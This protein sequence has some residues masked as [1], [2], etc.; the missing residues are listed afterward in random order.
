M[1]VSYI[2][3]VIRQKSKFCLQGIMHMNILKTSVQAEIEI[4]TIEATYI[5]LIG[6]K[7]EK[8]RHYICYP[9]PLG[10]QHGQMKVEEPHQPWF[11]FQLQETAHLQEIKAGKQGE[12][13]Q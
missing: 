13:E 2:T 11:I 3:Q 4:R 5:A 1:V 12:C 7:A 9:L 8:T 6:K 10:L